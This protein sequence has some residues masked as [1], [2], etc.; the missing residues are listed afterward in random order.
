MKADEALAT[1]PTNG[2]PGQRH[3][4]RLRGLNGPTWNS[5]PINLIPT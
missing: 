2:T 1:G 3:F 5:L 4:D